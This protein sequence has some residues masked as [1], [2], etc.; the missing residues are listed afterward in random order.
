M[1][2]NSAVLVSAVVLGLVV[3]TAVATVTS[4]KPKEDTATDDAPTHLAAAETDTREGSSEK[5]VT[6]AEVDTP[7]DTSQATKPN[8]SSKPEQPVKSKQPAKSK[9]APAKTPTKIAWEASFEK[10]LDKAKETGKPLMVDFYA[11]WCGACKHLDA[12]IYTAAPVIVE[13]TNFINVKVDADKRGDLQEKYQISG[14]PTIVWI[15]ST[16]SEVKRLRGAPPEPDYMVEMMR[17]A[18][19][20]SKRE[21][22]L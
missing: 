13:S 2:N 1:K 15:N 5:P 20:E 10:A 12:N 14:L 17:E 22:V 8:Q 4:T 7:T 11:D 3:I 6:T 16:G 18:R 19:T 21:S 9:Q